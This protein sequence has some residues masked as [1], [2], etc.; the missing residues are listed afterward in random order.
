[1][2]LTPVYFICS[3]RPLVGKTLLARQLT[4]YLRLAHGSALAFDVNLKE[5]TLVDY[6]PRLTETADVSDTRGQMMLMDQ[7]IENDRVP[8]VVDLG[9]HTFDAFFT[10]LY[11]VGYL[12]EAARTGVR[13][14]ILF[15]ADTDRASMRAYETLSAQ[16]PYASL[17]VVDNEHVL[18]GEMPRLY[19]SAQLLR[20][21]AV[22]PFLQTYIDRLD[23]S[24]TS[25]LRQEQDSSTELHQWI[26]GNYTKFR[27]MDMRL[28]T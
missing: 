18:R 28:L 21:P 8:K 25:Y 5:P 26:R 1:M 15:V 3:P 13:P 16:I 9:Y 14:F 7:L 6:L 2:P 12:K 17:A 24:F 23:F 20:I 11:E 22:Q 10:M 27:D 4:E 19:Q